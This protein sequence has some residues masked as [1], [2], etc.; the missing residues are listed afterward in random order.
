MKTITNI[1]FGLL[2]KVIFILC[3]S[4]AEL[5]YWVSSNAQTSSF[6]QYGVE[7]GLIQSQVQTIVQ[8]NEGNL[9]IGTTA[10]LSKYNGKSFEA[11]GKE[12]GLAEDYITTS[13]KDKQGNIWFGHWGGG[14]TTFN[15]SS[16]KF[17]N[18][19]LEKFTQ[20]KTLTSIFEDSSGNYWFGTSGA[21][22]I[23]FEITQ[24]TF[25]TI[26]K[27]NGLSSDNVT[28]ICQDYNGKLWIGTSNG[29]TIINLNKPLNFNTVDP[30]DTINIKT[31]EFEYFNNKNGLPENY[32]VNLKYTSQNK[33]WISTG[34]SGIAVYTTPIIEDKTQK[35]DVASFKNLQLITTQEGLSSDFVN[36]IFEDH[37]Q[38]IWLGTANKGLMQYIPDLTT[39]GISTNMLNGRFKFFNAKQGLNYNRVNSIIS[40]RENNIWIGTDLGLNQYR[41]ERFLLFDQDDGLVNSMVWSILEDSK[42]NLWFGTDGGIIKFYMPSAKDS[43][44]S[45]SNKFEVKN[46]TS[47]NGLSPASIS[48][49]YEDK[50]GILWITT[51]GGG[52]NKFNPENGKVEILTRKDGLPNNALTSITED[53]EGNF[54]LGTTKGVSKYDIKQNVFINYLDEDSINAKQINHIYKDTKGN[55]WICK[56]GGELTRFNGK[57]FERFGEDKGMYHKLIMSAAEDKTGNLWFTAYGGGIY[58]FNGKSFTNYTKKDGLSTD[59]PF[60]LISDD[61][62]N[63]WIGTSLGIDKFNQ[64]N[65]TFTHYGKQEGFLGIETIQN[66]VCKDKKGN[67]WFGTIMGVVKYNPQ[68]DRKNN[69][70]PLTSISKLQIFRKDAPFPADNIFPHNQNHLTFHFIG[71]SLTNSQKVSYQFQLLGFEK[72]W[73]PPVKL[74]HAE[75]SNLPFGKYTFQVKA[76]NND[77]I[78]N[79]QPV[80]Y[81]FEIL[82]P[83]WRTWWFYTLCVLLL[84]ILIY[85][86][87][88]YRIRR[89]AAEKKLLEEKVEV[90][91]H[92]L[93]E[94]KKKLEVAYKDLATEKDNVEKAYEV[95]EEKNKSITDSIEYA[96]R[97]QKAILPNIPS[98]KQVLPEMFIFYK[99]KAIVSGDFYWFTQKD[100][101]CVIAAVDC[102]GHGVPGAFMSIIG[103]TLLNQIVNEKSIVDPSTILSN[104][105]EGVK[106]A[107]HQRQE[108]AEAMDG[109][110]IALATIDLNN[111]EIVFAG[112]LRPLLCINNGETNY[113]KGNKLSIGG[114]QIKEQNIYISHTIKIGGNGIFYMFS[115]G[116]C[117]QFG[118]PRN[119]KLSSKGVRELLFQCSKLP[120]NE[121]HKWLSLQFDKWKGSH[122]QIDDVMV[123]G[124]KLN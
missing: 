4:I 99:P 92:Q 45:Y 119:K 98:I 49:I 25:F 29:I 91:T 97:I 90:R 24:L 53:N 124:I 122:E 1:K 70:A 40:D 60:L 100:K 71:V 35:Y 13:F 102:T 52:I 104:L 79:E 76:C 78:W 31:A 103:Y 17:E 111:K 118:G 85:A 120:V 20:F 7:Q 11:Y 89:I 10:G 121:Q 106:Q 63:I 22:I 67:L 93:N 50:I 2:S 3:L 105:D 9:W 80:M 112:A 64:K 75:Y 84:I 33:M 27:T 8:D 18:F 21:G 26:A 117:D 69:S 48:S 113:I 12:N 87:L 38:N 83:F 5:L 68:N 101:K 32:I 43:V 47:E 46:F 65:S 19:N 107:L 16:K 61:D 66:A 123:I 62:N 116:I 86:F 73:S 37:D 95:I 34:G 115:D 109:M 58:K 39:Q 81:N 51:Y 28:S 41:G 88:L 56:V 59:S 108:G 110:D 14:I 114:H 72:E 30:E 15:S 44:S 94:E 96:N 74:N 6:I 23:F 57:K 82:T 54:W 77:G 42:G 36:T 55:I